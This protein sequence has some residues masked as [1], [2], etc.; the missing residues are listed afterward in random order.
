[1]A[2]LEVWKTFEENQENEEGVKKVQNMM[3]VVSKKRHV[4]EETGQTVEG[5]PLS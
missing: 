2:L 4:D 5:M 3:P 1:V